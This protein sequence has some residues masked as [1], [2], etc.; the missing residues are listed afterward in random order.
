MTPT[1]IHALAR[2]LDRVDYYK[3]LRVERGAP[4][5][6]IRRAYHDSRRQFHPD[7]YLNAAAELREAVD[8]VAKRITEA[9]TTLRSAGRRAAYDRG[10]AEGRLRYSAEAEE[11]VRDETEAELGSTPN[12][13]RFFALA[14][15]AE[16]AGDAAKAVSHLRM[17]LTFEPK[18]EAFKA[19]LAEL[20][21]RVKAAPASNPFRIR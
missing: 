4:L 10:L 2:L 11:A 18:N 13:R 8:R 21:P 7:A 19:K 1:E 3:L 17:A 12:G 9:Y 15:E 5:A 16:R 14:R 6:E 20:E